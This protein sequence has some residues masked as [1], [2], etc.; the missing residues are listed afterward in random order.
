MFDFSRSLNGKFIIG[1]TTGLVSSF[2]IFTV[3]YLSQYQHQLK[4]E[5]AAA[6]R[7][8]NL[9]L[10]TSLEN[11]MLK[12][13]LVGLSSIVR[14]LGEQ[15]AIASVFITNPRGE[16]RF[17]S[18]PNLIGQ[19]YKPQTDS[20]DKNLAHSI[21]IRNQEGVDVFRSINPVTN[22]APCEECHGP[23]QLNPVNGIL[24][25]DFVGEPVRQHAR[26]TT[27][28][29]MATGGLIVVINLLGGWW[30][31]RRYV[32][33]P[34]NQLSTSSQRLMQGNLGARSNLT[35]D[36]ELSQLGITL[37]AMAGHL[38]HNIE[39][40]E[41]HQQFMQSLVDAIPDGIR[42]IDPDNFQIVLINN[43]YRSQLGLNASDVGKTCY[44]SSF[45]RDKPCVATLVTCPVHEIGKNRTPIKSLQRFKR[46]DG[47]TMNV[48]VYAAPLSAHFEGV[49]RNL[50]VESIRNLDEAVKYS[51]EQKLSELGRL[52]AGVAHEIHNPLASI[53]LALGACSQSIAS[54]E[55]NDNLGEYLELVDKEVEK[56]INITLRLLKLSAG[57]SSKQEIVCLREV[58]TDM[59]SLLKWEIESHGIVVRFNQENDARILASDS[60]MRMI[61]LNIIHNAM[62]AMPQGGSLYINLRSDHQQVILS[63]RDT[64][65][66]IAERDLERIFDPFF[67]RRAD[68]QKGVG[69]GLSICRSLCK[70]HAGKITGENAADQ[71]A[72]FTLIFPNPDASREST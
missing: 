1:M 9:L 13:D 56:C 20:S 21:Q 6:S 39:R 33:N 50:V 51:Q 36:D 67:S 29:L 31:F 72:I 35:G 66:G 34:L 57:S 5:R 69:L 41:Q 45:S 11:A 32:L 55:G 59:I 25:V 46:P 58:V 7:Q 38:Q 52:A 4:A 40:L 60:E 44:A 62:H 42:I 24:Y 18:D 54:S 68:G 47:K 30:F 3:L 22:R 15:Q 53:R 10:Q 8:V 26:Q 14:Q 48:E 71:G 23:S 19:Q 17:S 12:R 27:L 70:N 64:G 28:V 43:T 16:I 63:F 49:P 2:V 61:V 37:D 65:C